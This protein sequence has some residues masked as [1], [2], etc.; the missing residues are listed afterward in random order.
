M[1]SRTAGDNAQI[2]ISLTG[3]NVFPNGNPF[4]YTDPTE[5]AARI[6]CTAVVSAAVITISAST[7]YINPE[8]TRYIRPGYPPYITV[9]INAAVNSWVVV[10]FPGFITPT[11][12]HGSTMTVNVFRD[13]MNF[14]KY[15]TLP[16]QFWSPYMTTDINVGLTSQAM[17]G[18]FNQVTYSG[19]FWDQAGKVNQA[20]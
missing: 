2:V 19:Y 15:N 10:Y 11:N 5:S 18:G 16:R 9:R 14:Q 3:N 6:E 1:N 17:N 13:T 12:G 20:K 4:K 7:I 8:C